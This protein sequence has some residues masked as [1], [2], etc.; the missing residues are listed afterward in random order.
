MRGERLRD[1]AVEGFAEELGVT[2]INGYI[3]EE[4]FRIVRDAMQ[5]LPPACRKV[6]ELVLEGYKA[7]EIAGQL[8][9]AEE[10]V[11]KQ[12]KAKE[13]AGQLGI[14]EETV[15]KQKQIA[16]KILKEQLG[17][18]CLFLFPLL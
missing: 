7:K 3:A 10:T 16:R 4:T 6:F 9:I 13:I 2:E 11:K 1:K 8:G 17:R 15:K 12:Y 14:A 18:L 5:C